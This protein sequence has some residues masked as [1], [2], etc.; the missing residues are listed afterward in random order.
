MMSE[1]VDAERKADAERRRLEQAQSNLERFR[2][3][4]QM[5]NEGQSRRAIAE[6]LGVT[7]RQLYRMLRALRLEDDRGLR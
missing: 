3:V 7:K 2:Q 4:V 1:R 6:R 5:W